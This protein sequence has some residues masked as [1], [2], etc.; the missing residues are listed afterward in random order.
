MTSGLLGLKVLLKRLHRQIIDLW[1]HV[2]VC[3]FLQYAAATMTLVEF[4]LTSDTTKPYCCKLSR[5]YNVYDNLVSFL[6]NCFYSPNPKSFIKFLSTWIQRK[7]FIEFFVHQWGYFTHESV[8]FFYCLFRKLLLIFLF[9]C[10]FFLLWLLV[11]SI[12]LSLCISLG[13]LWYFWFFLLV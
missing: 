6:K 9:L 12:I 11:L 3:Y 8:K 4:Q 1:E 13:F 5:F 2:E 7:V 10:I